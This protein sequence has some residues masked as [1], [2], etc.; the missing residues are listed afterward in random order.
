M[1]RQYRKLENKVRIDLYL[2]CKTC[3]DKKNMHTNEHIVVGWT[4]E[5]IQVFCENCNNVIVDLDFLDQKVAYYTPDKSQRDEIIQK[6]QGFY[7]EQNSKVISE[8]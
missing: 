8:T 2:H 3:F 5:G 4:K 7:G 1:T 6:L